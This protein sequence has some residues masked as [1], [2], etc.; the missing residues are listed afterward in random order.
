MNCEELNC[1]LLQY[2]VLVRLAVAPFSDNLLDVV[3]VRLAVLREE[4]LVQHCLSWFETKLC[5]VISNNNPW[6]REIYI[7]VYR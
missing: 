4:L 1:T 3:L 5:I 2:R 7:H 6:E